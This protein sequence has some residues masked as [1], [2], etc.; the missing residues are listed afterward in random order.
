MHVSLEQRKIFAPSDVRIVSTAIFE[1]K[2]K[3]DVR[4]LHEKGDCFRCDKQHDCDGINGRENTSDWSLKSV[5]VFFSCP[6]A[7]FNMRSPLA[8]QNSHIVTSARHTQKG[9]Q[10]RNGHRAKKRVFSPY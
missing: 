3:T 1:K 5:S 9:K 7:K 2:N 4:N 6:S 8:F 10:Q